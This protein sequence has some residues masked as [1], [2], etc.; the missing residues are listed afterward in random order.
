MG[1]QRRS[2]L[3]EP[4]KE[5]VELRDGVGLERSVGTGRQVMGDDDDMRGRWASP[6]PE[7]THF[8]Q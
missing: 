5:A 8:E 4:L 2:E 6:R 3:Q 7:S 1:P